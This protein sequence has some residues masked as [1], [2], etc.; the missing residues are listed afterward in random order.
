[1]ARKPRE[2]NKAKARVKKKRV[3][4][5]RD[6]R[7]LVWVD[8]APLMAQE[9]ALAK[10]LSAELERLS[11]ELDQ[12]F[13]SDRPAFSRWLLEH[14]G[15]SLTS[16]DELETRA[17]ELQLT[18]QAV[19]AY[20]AA[21]GCTKRD[22]YAQIS[23]TRAGAA[24]LEEIR[25]RQEAGALPSALA[26]YQQQATFPDPPEE[27]SSEPEAR[28]WEAF[29]GEPEAPPEEGAEKCK[30]LFREIARK[31]HPD[32]NAALTRRQ[33]EI[34]HEAKLAYRN[35]DATALEALHALAAGGAG[36]L[37][38]RTSSLSSLR[39][40]RSILEQRADRALQQLQLART[41]RSWKFL[42]LLASPLR[43]S[44]LAANL[45]KEIARETEAALARVKACERQIARWKI[46]S[47]AKPRISAK[48][49]SSSPQLDLFGGPGAQ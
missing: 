23:Q 47:P 25:A 12:H 41:E 10:K 38:R 17:R 45:R 28:E 1:M 43:S 14:F 22:A 21:F 6:L 37:S 8:M 15:E 33:R 13:H 9:E 32:L 19:E 11:E 27:P 31:L 16:L 30:M 42:D 49:Q 36:P 20:A 48:K 24:Y 4:H 3:A 34:W 44:I 39:E 26:R 7:A 40:I 35:G 2:K 29:A 46:S 18:A 5:A